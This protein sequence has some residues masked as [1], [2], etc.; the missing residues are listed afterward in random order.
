M[1]APPSNGPALR[2][3]HIPAAPS[4]WPPAPGWWMLLALLIAGSGLALWRWRRWHQRRTVELALLAEVGSLQANLGSQP[5]QLATQW[6]AL[7]RRAALRLDAS[8][9]TYRGKA[10]E[11]LLSAVAP[12]QGM[13]EPLLALE[14]AMYRP[15]AS[16]DMD[17][18]AIALRRWLLLAWRYRPRRTRPSRNA[19]PAIEQEAER[20]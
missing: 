10:W 15:D 16:F 7:L 2:D 18:T 19:A 11:Q 17:G 5:Q 4:W 20:A 13:L 8:A 6:H 14:P 3:I 1:I 12:D 9:G